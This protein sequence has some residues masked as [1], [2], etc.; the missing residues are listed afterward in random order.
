MDEYLKL[1]QEMS[2]FK[3]QFLYFKH[4]GLLD[5]YSQ[6]YDLQKRFNTLAGLI[7][8]LDTQLHN[9]LHPEG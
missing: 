3:E 5:L 1:N 6:I 7:K 4:R 8:D 9:H 2:E